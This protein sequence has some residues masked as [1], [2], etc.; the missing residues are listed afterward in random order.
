MAAKLSAEKR[1]RD[2]DFDQVRNEETFI[3]VLL[4]LNTM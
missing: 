1:D 4:Q 2:Q 3:F